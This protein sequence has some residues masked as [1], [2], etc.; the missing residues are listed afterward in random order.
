MGGASRIV[1]WSTQAILRP[2]WR[3]WQSQDEH[4]LCEYKHRGARLQTLPLSN[5]NRLVYYLLFLSCE[6]S[7]LLYDC[8]QLL[9]EWFIGNV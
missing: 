4:K 1:Q 3:E 2:K 8:L 7:Y 5:I 6:I 9:L